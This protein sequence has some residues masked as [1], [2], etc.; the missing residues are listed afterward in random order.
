MCGAHQASLLFVLGVPFS[1]GDSRGLQGI[2]I[3]DLA[4]QPLSQNLLGE[5]VFL[6]LCSLWDDFPG[7]FAGWWPGQLCLLLFLELLLQWS[8]C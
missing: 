7:V 5:A 2:L 4:V 1:S 3:P 6:Y 8:G